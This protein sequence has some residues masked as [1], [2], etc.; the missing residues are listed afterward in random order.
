MEVIS[1]ILNLLLAFA[2]IFLWYINNRNA[3]TVSALKQE[4]SSLSNKNNVLL[5]SYDQAKSDL[6]SEKSLNNTLQNELNT[7]STQTNG[8][9]SENSSQS[10]QT[11]DGSSSQ[12]VQTRGSGNDGAIDLGLTEAEVIKIMGTPT[13][14]NDYSFFVVWNY[15]LSTIKFDQNGKVTGWKNLDHNL[16]LK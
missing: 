13:S 3:K 1:Y 12:T 11:S 14:I 6:T 5:Q 16:K 2:L 8:T 9:N 7:V 15:G 4:N 10:K